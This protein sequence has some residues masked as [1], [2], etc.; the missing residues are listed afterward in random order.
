LKVGISELW[1]VEKIE[2][3]CSQLQVHPFG[4]PEI[5]EHGKIY[6]VL[7]RTAQDATPRVAKPGSGLCDSGYNSRRWKGECGGIVPALK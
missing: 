6:V 4:K 7:R 2:E 5:L 1:G 3:F